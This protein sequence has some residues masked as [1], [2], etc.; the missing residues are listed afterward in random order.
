MAAQQS[1][2][3]EPP[4]AAKPAQGVANAPVVPAS[5]SEALE[6]ELAMLE[7]ILPPEAERPAQP[8]RVDPPSDRGDTR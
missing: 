5:R 4:A 8:T 2:S 7:A 6:A 1:D 3:P